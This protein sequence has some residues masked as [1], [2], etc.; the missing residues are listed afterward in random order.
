M[1]GRIY[2]VRGVFDDPDDPAA[3]DLVAFAQ[4]QDAEAHALACNESHSFKHADQVNYIVEERD[5]DE[6]DQETS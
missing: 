1:M 3:G 6:C 2:V 4:R 5:K